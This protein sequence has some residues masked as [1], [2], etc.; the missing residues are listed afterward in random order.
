M[1]GQ[2]TQTTL[3]EKASSDRSRRAFS[4][5]EMLLVLVLLV[6]IAG[7]TLPALRGALGSHRLREGAKSVRIELA[8]ARLRAMESGRSCVLRYA[9]G[10]R[11]FRVAWQDPT[12]TGEQ[13]EGTTRSGSEQ[14][15]RGTAATDTSDELDEGAVIDQIELPEGVVFAEKSPSH[16]LGNGED[17]SNGAAG[18]LESGVDS[19][20]GE[21]WSEPVI[22]YPDGRTTDSRLLLRNEREAYVMVTLRGLTGVVKISEMFGA[23]EFQ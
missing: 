12:E 7:L 4:L 18:P 17:E 9:P 19:T 22:F 11:R 2:I 13:S 8:K 3:K 6:T 5:L 21:G 20:S 10:E 16:G 1:I 23:G 15:S 14:G